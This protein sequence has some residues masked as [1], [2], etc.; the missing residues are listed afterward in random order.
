MQEMLVTKIFLFFAAKTCVLIGICGNQHKRGKQ[1]ENARENVY[2]LHN[3]PDHPCSQ[4]TVWRF[5][6]TKGL[7]WYLHDKEHLSKIRLL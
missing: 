4:N 6:G 5:A 1:R 3:A 7:S 2:V